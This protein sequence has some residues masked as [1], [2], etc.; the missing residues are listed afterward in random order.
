MS[1][2]AGLVAQA[3]RRLDPVE[4]GHADVHQDDVG[5][6]PLGLLDR[7]EAVG[8]LADD[9]EVILGVEDHAEPGADERLVV[10]DQQAHAQTRLNS[11]TSVGRVARTRQPS[12]V[13]PASKEPP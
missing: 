7:V 1:T 9:L 8:G 5:L 2:R 13:G 6:Q 4:L 11:R 3:P 12:S 10:S